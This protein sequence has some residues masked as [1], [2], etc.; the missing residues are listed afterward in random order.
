[1]NT[2]TNFFASTLRLLFSAS[3]LLTATQS[4]EGQI[5]LAADIRPGSAAGNPSELI[6][7]NGELYFRANN[8]TTG[9]ELFKYDGSSVSLVANIRSGSAS[10]AP[11]KF[12]THNGNLFFSANNGTNGKELF[13]YNGSSATLIEDIN[14][15]S[16]HSNPANMASYNGELVFAA[17]SPV[18]GREP[19]VYNGSTVS[20]LANLMT[21]NAPSNPQY[22]VE[23][24]GILYFNAD[25]PGIGKELT[26]YNGAT[27][28]VVQDFVSGPGSLNPVHLVVFNNKLFFSGSNG[29]NGQELMSYNG[30][31]FNLEA[32]IWLGGSLQSSNPSHLIVYNGKLYF[33][34]NDGSTGIELWSFDGTT[35]TNVADINP[36]TGHSYVNHLEVFDG[37]L[38]FVAQGPSGAEIYVYDGATTTLL[39]DLVPGVG[40]SHPAFL[41]T[42]NNKLY[43]RANNGATGNEL[44]VYEEL[45]PSSVTWEGNTN[46]DWNTGSNWSTGSVP[47]NTGDVV[48][49]NVSNDP[50]I[51]NDVSVNDIT[52]ESG[53]T[54][55]VASGGALTLDGVL[56]NSGSV[57][58][59]SGGN[60]LQ[61]SSSS[62][63]GFGSF[64]VQRQGA[65]GS[66]FNYWSSPM[67]SYSGVPGGNTYLFNPNTATESYSDDLD[68]DPGWISHNG[69]MTP[70][71]GYAGYGAGLA[72]F[73]GAPNNGDVNYPLTYYP[74]SPG[75]TSPGSPSN[76]CGNPYPSAIS[77]LDLVTTNTDIDGAIYFWDDDL[78]GGSD[79]SNS[80][81][82][83]WNGTGS[84]GTGGGTVAP[85][86]YIASCQGFMVRAAT[87]GAVLNFT[88]SMR[89]GNSSPFFRE[90]S[91]ENS[92]MWLSLSN[93][94]LRSQ[95][96][97]AVLEDAT[98]YSD[99]L[100]DAEKI[101]GNNDIAL[102]SMIDSDEFC[103][104]AVAPSDMDRI[105]PLMTKVSLEGEFTFRVDSIEGFGSGDMV[106]FDD[107]D[108]EM[109]PLTQGAEYTFNISPADEYGRFQLGVGAADLTDVAITDNNDPIVIFIS[110]Y[111][112]IIDQAKT[113]QANIGMF[114]MMGRSIWHQ[115]VNLTEGRNIINI[116]E[117]PAGQYII[118]VI[119]TEGYTSKQ[120]I[121][122]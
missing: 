101:R 57:T 59:Q 14:I 31:T 66:A 21:G 75:N 103:I 70:G 117:V 86:G 108:G 65:T 27:V 111:D 116:P 1:M 29:I 26:S 58:I 114:D 82:A 36:G 43:F 56:D 2:L 42:F 32:D 120:F 122:Y 38:Y 30:S 107:L 11:Q 104:Q 83:V 41:T 55:N 71:R 60:F 10:G 113:G 9:N 39:E 6:V 13:R 4:A 95:M 64:N 61:G 94:D 48:I 76:L 18:E 74:A 24:N 8:G 53:A 44:Y 110:N 34:A 72:T 92:R 12:A 106:L 69:G 119:S 96:L 105:V 25:H 102:A 85:N 115:G 80:D 50:V 62:I 121:L 67:Q 47:S 15:G 45:T 16:G 112:L 37:K 84:L 73:T 28:S 54:L 68:P 89:S 46:S 3:L 33:S 77:C 81:Y 91:N 20:N 51:S 87:G 35:A 52:L 79:Y 90:A 109:Y 17:T 99:R 97:F 98:D 63:T 100:Y 19:F 49:P 7:H 118:Q 23:Y 88:N 5:S 22:F 78:S 93:Q 40:G